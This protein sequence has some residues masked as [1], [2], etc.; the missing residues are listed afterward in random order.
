[1]RFHRF[2]IMLALAWACSAAAGAPTAA[3]TDDPEATLDQLIAA[4]NAR[5]LD[6]VESLLADSRDLLWITPGQA[7]HG[8][9]AAIEHLRESFR[10]PSRIDLDPSTVESV[11]LD[12]STVEVLAN[13][14]ISDVTAIR[15][16]QISAIL[17][18]TPLGW[19]VQTLVLG[20]PSPEAPPDSDRPEA[21]TRPIGRAVG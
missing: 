4:H 13:G 18:A 8:R 1:M 15:E 2:A 20:I 3:G 11:R 5:D 19:R 17:V 9:A 10:N 7:V 14:R 16:V 12:I 21:P 6:G